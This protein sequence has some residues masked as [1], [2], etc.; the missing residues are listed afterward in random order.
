MLSGGEG[1]LDGEVTIISRPKIVGRKS[2]NVS[3]RWSRVV[4]QDLGQADRL[5]CRVL[6]SISLTGDGQEKIGLLRGSPESASQS[7]HGQVLDGNL[8][9][10]LAAVYESAKGRW[11]GSTLVKA[12]ASFSNPERDANGFEVA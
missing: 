11:G 5:C 10:G 4:R 6:L 1:K 7:C 8:F 3:P 12:S 9:P 2:V